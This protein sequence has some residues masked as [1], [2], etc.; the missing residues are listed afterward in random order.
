MVKAQTKD[1]RI[2]LFKLFTMNSLHAIATKI[3]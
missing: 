2:R 1:K 3:P